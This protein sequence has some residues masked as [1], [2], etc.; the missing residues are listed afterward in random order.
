MA[1]GRGLDHR[2]CG[3]DQALPDGRTERDFVRE[4]SAD[5]RFQHPLVSKARWTITSC[6]PSM[7]PVPDLLSGIKVAQVVTAI[8]ALGDQSRTSCVRYLGSGGSKSQPG[9]LRLLFGFWGIKVDKL[10]LLF[11]FWGIKVATWQVATAVWVLG[12]QS[13]TSCVR[14]LGSGGSKSHKLDCC[15]GSGGSK[16]HKLR[17]LLG[18]GGSQSQPGKLRPLFGLW[19]IKVVQVVFA[20]W[21]LGDQSRNLAS[22]TAIWVLGDQSR[23]SCDCC[24]GSGGSKSHKLRLLFG[25]WGSQ[26]QPG[27]LRPLFGLWGIKVVQVVFAIWVL[28]DQSRNLASFVQVARYLGSGGS[29]SQA[30]KLRLLFGFWGIRLSCV[31]WP[32]T[33]SLSGQSTALASDSRQ[34]DLASCLARCQAAIMGNNPPNCQPDIG[35]GFGWLWTV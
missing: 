2:G 12:D 18:S 9:K 21:V 11:G 1:Q 6:S 23:T 30:G 33:Q 35:A 17:L 31:A 32:V 34:N 28:G 26:S 29:K 22:W 8:W 10:R 19:G 24:L 27:K 16:S 15:L 20:I 5:H 4:E 3:A 7:S 25:F 14:Y 13:R